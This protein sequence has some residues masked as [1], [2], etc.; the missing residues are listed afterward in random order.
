MKAV[1]HLK[2]CVS[3]HKAYVN[4]QQQN[5]LFWTSR[6]AA[7]DKIEGP[8]LWHFSRRFV[9]CCHVFRSFLFR[10]QLRN[11]WKLWDVLLPRGQST[12]IWDGKLCGSH[13]GTIT[14][15]FTKIAIFFISK[16]DLTELLWAMNLSAE[17]RV[18]PLSCDALAATYLWCCQRVN[19]RLI[20]NLAECCVLARCDGGWCRNA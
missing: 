16:S 10:E 6:F 14:K 19:G 4:G 15:T 8:F 17:R 7:S 5:R 1:N 12:P 2:F 9:P 11:N 20:L 3:T 13:D 18:S